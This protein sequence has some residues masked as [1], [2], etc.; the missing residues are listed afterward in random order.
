MLSTWAVFWDPKPNWSAAWCRLVQIRVKTTLNSCISMPVDVSYNTLSLLGSQK[1]M[2]NHWF[3]H[4]GC[5]RWVLQTSETIMTI[6]YDVVKIETV[7]ILLIMSDSLTKHQ[8]TV[9]MNLVWK[10]HK[11]PQLLA[12]FQLYDFGPGTYLISIIFTLHE[13]IVV[14]RKF[15]KTMLKTYPCLKGRWRLELAFFLRH[16]VH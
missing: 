10:I 5:A 12:I 7:T 16:P 8:F 3:A 9:N 15:Q 2:R 1:T 14:L 13:V 4:R 6:L 11:F